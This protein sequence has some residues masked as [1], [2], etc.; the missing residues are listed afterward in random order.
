MLTIPD[1]CCGEWR[2]ERQSSADRALA[3]GNRRRPRLVD[4]GENC[5]MGS[6]ARNTS[7]GHPGLWE[8]SGQKYLAR[9]TKLNPKTVHFALAELRNERYLTGRKRGGG[10]RRHTTLFDIAFPED[11]LMPGTEGGLMPGTGGEKMNIPAENIIPAP[12]DGTA[13]D[14]L[15]SLDH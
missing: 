14:Q 5:R 3:R 8:K 9:I 12:E 10:R 1:R 6:L 11:G 7:E 4:E 2:W 13:P 15:G